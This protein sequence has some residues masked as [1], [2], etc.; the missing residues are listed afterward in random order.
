MPVTNHEN[1]AFELRQ[2]DWTSDGNNIVGVVPVQDALGD[3][4]LSLARMNITG[5]NPQIDYIESPNKFNLNPLWS[6]SGEWIAYY[7]AIGRNEADKDG[8][9]VRIVDKTGTIDFTSG[10]TNLVELHLHYT[11]LEAYD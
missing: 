3:F 6:P 4:T 2:I 1:I 5:E 10:A 7:S 9:E 8:V 11:W